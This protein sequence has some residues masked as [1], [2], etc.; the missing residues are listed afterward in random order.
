MRIE[1]S[2]D[3]EKN[4]EDFRRKWREKSETKD[5][6]YAKAIADWREKGCGWL[7]MDICPL[8][9]LNGQH[10][11]N[12][13]IYVS[14]GTSTALVK[15]NQ[16]FGR[17]LF[18]KTPPEQVYRDGILCLVGGEEDP[19][20]DLP[21]WWWDW[22]LLDQLETRYEYGESYHGDYLDFVPTLWTFLPDVPENSEE[23]P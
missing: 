1:N 9:A 15:V 13:V 21:K 22:E 8:E 23:G 11:I 19:R 4:L 20:E 7:S 2:P 16:R 3:Y 6:A 5:A 10:G 12:G 14:D 17:P 18:W